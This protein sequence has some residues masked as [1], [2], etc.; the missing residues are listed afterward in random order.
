MVPGSEVLHNKNL[1]HVYDGSF[2][3]SAWLDSGTQILGQKHL[4]VAFK[5]IN[6]E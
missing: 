2:S 5:W 3:V 4:D 1:K 6:F